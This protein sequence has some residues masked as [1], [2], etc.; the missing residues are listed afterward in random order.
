MILYTWPQEFVV[1]TAWWPLMAC[2]ALENAQNDDDD[3]TGLPPKK[4]QMQQNADEH[5]EPPEPPGTWDTILTTL[6]LAAPVKT[7]QTASAKIVIDLDDS[8]TFPSTDS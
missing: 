5:Y 8:M 1:K 6:G 7:E 4:T 3:D 2:R